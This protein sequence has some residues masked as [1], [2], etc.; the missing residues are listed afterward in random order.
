M[1]FK[2]LF[3]LFFFCTFSYQYAI[4]STVILSFNIR[5]DNPNDGENAWPNRKEKVANTILF[6]NADIIGLQEV[7]KHQLEDLEHLL[8][9]KYSWEGVGRTDGKEKGEYSPIFYNKE[10]FEKLESETFWLSETPY[11]IGSKGWDAALPRIVTWI[12]FKERESGKEFYVFNTHFDHR[13]DTAR[14]ESAKL[15]V[16]KIE[17]IADNFPV[18]LTGDFNVEPSSEPYQILVQNLTNV[19]TISKLPW[20]GSEGTFNGFDNPSNEWRAI[21]FI[22]VKGNLEVDKAGTLSTSWD[23]FYASDHFP[24]FAEIEPL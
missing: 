2:S 15:I 14:M 17:E 9:E 19:Q 3:I 5:Y 4:S 22:F 21:D 12:K 6:H 7:L 10:K 11:K 8:P 13:G 1:S 20:V 16:S 23:G 24:I 18:V